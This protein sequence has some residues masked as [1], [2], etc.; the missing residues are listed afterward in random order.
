MK[1]NEEKASEPLAQASFPNLLT[2][3]DKRWREEGM[4]RMKRRGRGAGDFLYWPSS[5]LPFPH[6]AYTHYY[7]SG[8]SLP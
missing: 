5:F 1:T 2:L 8:A 4:K 6:F 3:K 7:Y